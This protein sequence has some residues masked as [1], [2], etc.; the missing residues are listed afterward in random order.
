MKKSISWKLFFILLAASG[1]TTIMVMPYAFSLVRETGLVITPILL[2]IQFI[3]AMLLFAVAIFFGL[4]LAARVGFN[5]P[6][7]E[8]AL[9]GEKQCQNIKNILWPSISLGLL[10]TVLIILASIPFGALSLDF[11]KVAM[12]VPTW[13][14]LLASFYG[15]IGEEILLRLFFMTF[16][17]WL[18]LKFKKTSEGRPTNTGV[19]LAI[20]LAAV[21]FGLGHLPIT[22]GLAAITPV[23]V[24]RAIILNGIGGIIFGW[25]YWKK[26]LEAAMISHFSADIF[27]HVITPLIASLFI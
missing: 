26:G 5:L 12:A 14:S 13:V 19:W 21:I 23:V 7:L 20:I 9:K 4:K 22:S 24:L 17:V 18:T 25:L 8:G 1:I 6:I 2:I 3:Q 16:F 10:V 15:G 11:L 27:L